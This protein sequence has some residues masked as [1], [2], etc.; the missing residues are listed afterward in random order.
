LN[1][2]VRK[3]VKQTNEIN[4][5]DGTVTITENKEINELLSILYKK[6]KT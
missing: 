3:L 4:G 6:E 1:E 2:Y 5:A